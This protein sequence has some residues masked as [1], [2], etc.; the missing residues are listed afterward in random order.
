M[1]STQDST[2]RVQTTEKVRKTSRPNME[3]QTVKRPV[4]IRRVD[5]FSILK[6]SLIFYFCMLLVAMLGV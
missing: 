5:P 2:K 3:K 4:M 1:S 6:I